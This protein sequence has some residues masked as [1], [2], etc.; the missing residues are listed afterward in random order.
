MQLQIVQHSAHGG[1]DLPASLCRTSG[2]ALAEGSHVSF[3][4]TSLLGYAYS[5]V[6]HPLLRVGVWGAM[7]ILAGRVLLY[8]CPT[9]HPQIIQL[10]QG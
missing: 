6:R 9:S 2:A 10:P 1:L 3:P 8:P 7:A 4:R 5:F